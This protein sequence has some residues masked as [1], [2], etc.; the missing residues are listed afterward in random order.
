VYYI[1]F[2]KS[3]VDEI[4]NSSV[5]SYRENIVY[6]VKDGSELRNDNFSFDQFVSLKFER[7]VNLSSILQIF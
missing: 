2:L 6:C 5:G 7:C 1:R 4:T 3:K